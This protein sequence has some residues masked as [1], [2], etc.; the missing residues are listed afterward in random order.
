MFRDN[1]AQ[2]TL[3]RRGVIR[4]RCTDERDE[5][6][7][8]KAFHVQTLLSVRSLHRHNEG[9]CVRSVESALN[10]PVDD[11]YRNKCREGP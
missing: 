6:Q 8:K 10:D 1:E 3:E 5:H 11:A 9:S 7:R 4:S 2:R